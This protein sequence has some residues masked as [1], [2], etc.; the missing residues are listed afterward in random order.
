MKLE[1]HFD[2]VQPFNPQD[3]PKTSAGIKLGVVGYPGDIEGG[4]EMYEHWD[5]TKI[6]L[7]ENKYLSYWIDTEVGESGSP[8]LQEITGTKQ[9][10][11]STSF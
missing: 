8:I 9:F 5:T 7:S 11:P 1:E 3:T 10:V 6:D 4:N 2:N